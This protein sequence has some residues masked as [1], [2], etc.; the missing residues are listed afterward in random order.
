MLKDIKFKKSLTADELAVVITVFYL[1]RRYAESDGWTFDPILPILVKRYGGMML[2]INEI[3]SI[4]RKLVNDKVILKYPQT[5]QYR[6]NDEFIITNGCKARLHIM[7]NGDWQDR[8][9]EVIEARMI[10]CGL[11]G[12][13]KIHFELYCVLYS[14]FELS[15]E[16]RSYIQ[17]DSETVESAMRIVFSNEEISFYIVELVSLGLII[18][19][20][21]GGFKIAEPYI[22]R[23]EDVP[24]LTVIPSESFNSRWDFIVRERM[25]R[26]GIKESNRVPF[27]VCPFSFNIVKTL[28]DNPGAFRITPR[29]V[30]ECCCISTGQSAIDKVLDEFCSVGVIERN[31]DDGMQIAPAFLGFAEGI[32]LLLVVPTE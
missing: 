23:L 11:P 28:F 10:R 30:W 31:P 32:P 6:V 16:T 4:L 20:G 5:D 14:I 12:P 3:A 26:T 21:K 22:C 27:K 13:Q 17:I 8:Y 15:R 25:R 1:S 19:D 9:N 29:H 24:T 2:S 18:H 7:F